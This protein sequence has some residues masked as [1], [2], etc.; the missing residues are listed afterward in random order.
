M[1]DIYQK[2]LL[3]NEIKAAKMKMMEFNSLVRGV[4]AV[5][6]D[7]NFENLPAPRGKNA[8]KPMSN[9]LREEF[10]QHLEDP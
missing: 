7:L 9:V 10:F 2:D 5:H 1:Q 3:Y 4:S 6:P 8:K